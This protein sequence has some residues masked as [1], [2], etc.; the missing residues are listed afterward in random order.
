MLITNEL[1]LVQIP[2]D[3]DWD[4]LLNESKFLTSWGLK[5]LRNG[6][7]EKVKCILIE[8]YYIC[9][10]HTNLYTNFYSKKFSDIPRY[11]ERFHFFS[12]SGFEVNDIIYN[13]TNIQ[14]HYIGYSVIRPIKDRCLGRS[15]FDQSKIFDKKSSYALSTRFEVNINGAKYYCN[16]YPYTSQDTEV[17]VCAHSALWGLCRYLSSRYSIYS[18]K[19]P[20]DFVNFT[21]TNLGRTFPYKGMTYTDYCNVL[22]QVGTYPVLLKI[23]SDNKNLNQNALNDLYTYIESGF[24]TLISF[25]S[26]VVTV[27]GHTTNYNIAIDDQSIPKDDFIDSFNFLKQFI[28][29]D[30]NFFPYQYLGYNDDKNNYGALYKNKPY[31]DGFSIDKIY[32]AICPLPEKVFL[33]ASMAREI[34]LKYFQSYKTALKQISQPPWI[35][36]LFLTTTTSFKRRKLSDSIDSPEDKIA[37]IISNFHM[38]HFIWVMEIY[39]ISSYCENKPFAEIILDPTS[40]KNDDNVIYMRIGDKLIFNNIEKTVENSPTYF[41][42]YTHNLGERK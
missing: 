37:Y 7:K 4:N 26:H 5:I 28:V 2:N 10:D 20:Y 1:I 6:L 18:E 40:G 23:M 38:P 13:P 19:Y 24:P 35:Y 29:V 30:D 15:V 33:Q 36:R 8:P 17:T 41:K 25:S 34:S 3:K 22:S 21:D 32:T 27:V 9:K 39:S 12:E 16:G 11:T 14:K 42:Q 31:P